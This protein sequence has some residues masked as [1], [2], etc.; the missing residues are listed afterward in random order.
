MRK[1]KPMTKKADKKLEQFLALVFSN[2]NARP[3]LVL[4]RN[5]RA[6]LTKGA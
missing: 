6:T 2:A 3:V 4:K 5:G 1:V